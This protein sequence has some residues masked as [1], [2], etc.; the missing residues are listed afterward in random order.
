VSKLINIAKKLTKNDQVSLATLDKIE[1]ILTKVSI[2]QDNITKAKIR[3]QKEMGEL[4]LSLEK[5]QKTCGH[6]VNTYHGDPSGGSDSS[7][8]CDICQLLLDRHKYRF[9]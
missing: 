3:H 2:C 6:E 8:T 7:H 4:K 5:V 9:T 1:S